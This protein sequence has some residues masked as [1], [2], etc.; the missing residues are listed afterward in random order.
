MVKYSQP[1]YLKVINDMNMEERMKEKMKKGKYANT[2]FS[3]YV[4]ASD[5]NAGIF[6]GGLV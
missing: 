1:M 4:C 5:E 3:L 2:S 6:E